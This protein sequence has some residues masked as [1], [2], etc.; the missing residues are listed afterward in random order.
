MQATQHALIR[1]QQRGIPA[2][3]IDAII[4]HGTTRRVPGGAV[5][6][7]IAKKSINKVMDN[8][9]KKDRITIDR[10]KNV[11]LV[12]GDESIITV[13]YRTRRFYN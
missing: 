12:I 4:E 5:A 10:H 3:V 8:L 7:F 11:Y 2:L 13:G 9:P 1:M 6:K